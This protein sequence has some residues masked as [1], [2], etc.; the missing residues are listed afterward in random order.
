MAIH[1]FKKEYKNFKVVPKGHSIENI[2]QIQNFEYFTQTVINCLTAKYEVFKVTPIC[3][4]KKKI[5]I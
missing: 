1:F 2:G 3:F 5:R 4:S